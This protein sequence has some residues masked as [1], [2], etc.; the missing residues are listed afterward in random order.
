MTVTIVDHNPLRS[1]VMADS[2]I[3]VAVKCIPRSMT[4]FSHIS[5]EIISK[6]PTLK[7]KKI[8]IFGDV[9]VDEYVQGHVGRISPEAPV[10]VV[11][12]KESETKLGLSANVAANIKSLG[13]E[14]LLVSVIGKDKSADVLQNLLTKRSI[15]SEHLII[16]PDRPTTSKLRVMSGHHHIVRVDYEKKS[17][18][19]DDVLKKVSEKIESLIKDLSLIHI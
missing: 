8:L 11:E 14:P 3:S 15:S 19:S 2:W 4:Q 5:K 9:G 17:P 6:L 10:P 1:G 18:L 16:D 13:G 7:G 12:V